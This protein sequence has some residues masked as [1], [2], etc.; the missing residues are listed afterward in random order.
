MNAVKIALAVAAALG[1]SVANAQSN[2]QIGGA[3]AAAASQSGALSG[4]SSGAGAAAVIE[5]NFEA[6]VQLRETKNTQDLNYSGTYTIR[7]VPNI[8]PPNILP[9]SPCMGSSSLGL[10][11]SG[12]GIG[13]GT[14]WKDDDCGYRETARVFLQA[15]QAADGMAVLCSSPYA[16]AAPTCQKLKP[17]TQPAKTS[18]WDSPKETTI[19]DMND[20]NRTA[21]TLSGMTKSEQ[22]TAL[23]KAA[24]QPTLAEQKA[25][26]CRLAGDDTILRGRF[27]CD[28]IFQP[29]TLRQ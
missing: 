25:A 8:A 20:R 23:T 26:N 5:Q 11:I 29:V 2:Q 6:P 16:A 14:S 24:M 3:N 15:G 13:G 21:T 10:G 17:A 12:F 9:T 7:N 18:A 22:D 19:R 4:S 28:G 1:V 27:G